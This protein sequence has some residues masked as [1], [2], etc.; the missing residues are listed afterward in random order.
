[1][2]A[3]ITESTV[4][5]RD[6]W[7]REFEKA[8]TKKPADSEPL[9]VKV[10]RLNEKLDQVTNGTQTPKTQPDETPTV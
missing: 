1:M 5:T 6:E 2:T 8:R 4:L 10:R 9:H 7:L 3:R